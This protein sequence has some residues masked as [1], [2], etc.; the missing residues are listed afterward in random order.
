MLRDLMHGPRSFGELRAGLPAI[1]DK[2][3]AE[4]LA[5]LRARGLVERREQR[6]FPTRGSYRLTPEGASLR[7]LLVELYRAGERLR[8][9]RAQGPG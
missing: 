2:V 9:R 1:S 8:A 4:R 7:P 6:G 5:G 3:L